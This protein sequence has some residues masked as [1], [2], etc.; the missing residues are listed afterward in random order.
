MVYDFL[1]NDK[2]SGRNRKVP[3]DHG[4]NRLG[5]RWRN[6]LDMAGQGNGNS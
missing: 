4:T 3:G 1:M 2:C 5:L 6:Y